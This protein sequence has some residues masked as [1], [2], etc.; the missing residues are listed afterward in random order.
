MSRSSLVNPNAGVSIPPVA[1]ASRCPLCN[2]L[3]P[4]GKALPHPCE[5]RGFALNTSSLGGGDVLNGE[6]RIDE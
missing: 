5:P 3:R 4:A 2:G 1:P 6:E